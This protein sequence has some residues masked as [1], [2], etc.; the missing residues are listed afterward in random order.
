VKRRILVV[1]DSP[2]SRHLLSG[3]LKTRGYEVAAVSGIED[4]FHAV[5]RV[6]PHA[7]LL[8]LQLCDDDGF[9]LAAWMREQTLLQQIPVIAVT[10]H[11]MAVE[12]E[13]VLE[14]R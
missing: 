12:E 1:S 14:M 8:D 13:G 4:A 11:S 9:L 5:V 3:R 6:H 10:P 7:V 2:L